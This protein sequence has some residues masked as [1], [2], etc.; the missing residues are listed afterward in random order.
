MAGCARSREHKGRGN[1]GRSRGTEWPTCLYAVTRLKRAPTVS[2]SH[3][4]VSAEVAASRRTRLGQSVG[5]LVR[6]KSTSNCSAES[7]IPA[8][9]WNRVAAAG[10]EPIVKRLRE[11]KGLTQEQFAEIS[12]FSQQYISSLE[13]GRRNPTV[14]TLYELSVALGVNHVDLIRPRKGRHEGR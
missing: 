11:K 1:A 12:G 6:I 9:R 10:T 5:P 14:I 3:S 7:T 2:T 8:L 13:R 4:T